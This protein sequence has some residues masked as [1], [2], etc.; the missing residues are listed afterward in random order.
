MGY[1]IAPISGSMRC[2]DKN[3]YRVESTDDVLDTLCRLQSTG[4]SILSTEYRVESTD[5]VLDTLCRVQSAGY[6]LQSTESGELVEHDW[7]DFLQLS[8][9]TV[10][11]LKPRVS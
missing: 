6:R 2:R 11:Q 9:L 5:D 10:A 3:C 7:H 8:C 1:R 4:Y